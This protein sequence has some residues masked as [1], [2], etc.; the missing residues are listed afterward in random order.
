MQ[1]PMR[2]VVL[3]TYGAGNG[4]DARED[5]LKIFKEACASGVIIVNIT[6]CM[7]GAV[8]AA[9]AAGKVV[10]GIEHFLQ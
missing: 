6:Q 10:I 4:P 8:S 2:G 5:L 3:Q 9:Y 1:P 7:K